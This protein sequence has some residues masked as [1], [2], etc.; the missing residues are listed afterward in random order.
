M[1]KLR[2]DRRLQGR[3]DPSDVLQDAYL[4]IARRTGVFGQPVDAGLSLAALDYW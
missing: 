1:V 4:D 3:I 2:M